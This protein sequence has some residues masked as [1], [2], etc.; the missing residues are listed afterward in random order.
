M[1]SSFRY[2]GQLTL[3]GLLEFEQRFF[4]GKLKPHLRS[5]LPLLTDKELPVL[6]V[7]ASSFSEMVIDNGERW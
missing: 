1:C 6:V 3:K 4:D 5:E 7:K 2:E